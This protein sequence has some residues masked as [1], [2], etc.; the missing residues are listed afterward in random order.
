MRK[1]FYALACMFICACT[2]VIEESDFVEDQKSEMHILTRSSVG[3]NYPMAL[4]AFDIATGSMTSHTIVSS[5]T[6]DAILYLPK[7]NYQ[8]VALTGL[9]AID[10]NPT[11]NDVITL[12]SY[13]DTPIQMGSAAVY[14][15]QN[16]TVSIM[17]YNQ[18]SA[19]DIMLS[20]IPA[21]AT[22]V[23]VSL[24]ILY[25]GLSYNGAFSGNNIVTISLEKDDDVWRSNRFYVLPTY[26]NQLTLSI[27][28]VTPDATSSY[29]YTHSAP[30]LVN[31]PYS[32]VGTLSSGFAINSTIDVAGWNPT[33]E[34][35][36]L[37]GGNTLEGDDETDEDN[38]EIF[39]VSSIPLSGELWD[40]HFVAATEEVTDTS[41]VL[42]LLSTTEWSDV[43]SA[44][45]AAAS[46]M[47]IDII[48]DYCEDN[49]SG[50]SIPT[51]DEAKLMRTAIGAENIT[52][53]NEVLSANAIPILQ[54]G[55]DAKGNSIRY[56]CDDATYSYV[57]D[58]TNI[59]KCGTKRTYH[60]RAV[61]KVKVKK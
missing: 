54:S 37:F 44:Y 33:E 24:S 30:F 39:R 2:P 11:L 42:L 10:K 57:W 13:M 26:G 18:V 31:T 47:A 58:A 36:F 59:S 15:T 56:L 43:S 9:P 6:D 48:K 23:S 34:I 28:I 29:G 27:T 41:A 5:D 21:D 49:L 16:S 19:V 20:D 45:N 17:L 61:K 3:I 51:R 55:K 22:D 14:A 60:L 50:W 32:L 25:D 12:S 1:L 35:K 8:I 52:V 46:G 38:L 4:Y 53:T 40:N 7:G